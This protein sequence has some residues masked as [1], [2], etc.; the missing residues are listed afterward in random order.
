[1]TL[2]PVDADAG[3]VTA[4][5]RQLLTLIDWARAA[6]GRD[7]APADPAD[8][9]TAA[10]ADA[11]LVA[12]GAVHPA[13]VPVVAVLGAAHGRVA[14]RRWRG[15]AEVPVVEI[16]SGPAG[17]LV[18]PGGHELDAV[19]ELRWHPRPAALP[20]VVA[21]A[22]DATIHDGPAPVGRGPMAWSELVAAAED[23]GG[24]LTLADVRWSPGTGVPLLSVLVV[25]WSAAG[26][27][28]EVTPIESRPGRLVARGRHPIEIW[29]GL[30]RLA[31]VR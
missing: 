12:N 11:G 21:E 25:V 6:G 4:T 16:L 31:A 30:T 7:G 19:Q 5:R 15:G 22:L 27:A 26:G 2:V 24:D 10:L 23:P 1:M 9:A 8:P 3:R 18:L 14:V 13:L 20:R 28:A 29:T 17:V